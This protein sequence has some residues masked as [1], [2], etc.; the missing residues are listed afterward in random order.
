MLSAHYLT[1]STDSVDAEEGAPARDRLISGDPKFR[2][3]NVE[4]REGGLYAG[5]WESTPGKWRIVYDE[6][7]FCH[8]LSGVSVIE[9]E[10]GEARTV[11]AGDSFVLRPGFKGSW[12]VL[13]TTRKEYV[14]RL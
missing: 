2:T 10:G 13:E 1:I 5:I 12:E 3:W 9:E 7:E 4:E 6:W 8:I 11:R 14:I